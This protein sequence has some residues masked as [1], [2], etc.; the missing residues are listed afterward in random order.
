MS[1]S[2]GGGSDVDADVPVQVFVRLRPITIP[3]P[4]NGSS[5]GSLSHPTSSVAVGSLF[6]PSSNSLRIHTSRNPSGAVLNNAADSFNFTAL[7]GLFNAAASQQTVF[8]SVVRDL[9]EASVFDG[10]DGC[11][12]AYGQTGAGKTYTMLGGTGSNAATMGMENSGLVA[13]SIAATFSLLRGGRGRRGGRGAVSVRFSMLELFEGRI[14]DLLAPTLDFSGLKAEMDAEERGGAGR[15]FQPLPSAA[16][17]A[18]LLVAE[19]KHKQTYITGLYTPVIKTEAEALAFLSSGT[20]NRAL[21]AHALNEAS[22]RAHCIMTIY[23]DYSGGNGSSSSSSSSRLD[24]VD[25]AG[26][27]RVAKTGAAGARLREASSINKSLSSLTN[28]IMALRDKTPHIPYRSS[29]LTHLL[30]GS[31]G[32]GAGRTRLIAAL[33]PEDAHTEEGIATMRFAAACAAVKTRLR[34][35]GGA[36]GD[37]TADMPGSTLQSAVHARNLAAARADKVAALAEVSLLRSELALH[38]ELSGREPSSLRHYPLT[39]DEEDAVARALDIFINNNNSDDHVPLVVAPLLGGVLS[40]VRHVEWALAS[41][42]ARVRS[43]EA[44][45]LV[46]RMEAAAAVASGVLPVRSRS[47]LEEASEASDEGEEGGG[48]VLSLWTTPSSRYLS[49]R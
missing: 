43:S 17:P 27:E 47:R 29:K 6:T 1:D 42:R 32:G 18:A 14:I 24:L 48:G 9:V 49:E 38:D 44:A 25:L 11:V 40:S 4:T 8:D 30:K 13:R 39:P 46:S 36:G 41:L 10:V 22:T 15:Q 5:F 3:A 20:A 16:S 33:W 45:A 21:A 28:V 23:C 31:L 37:T 7:N 35:A 26:S 12:L 19:D 34:L 2:F